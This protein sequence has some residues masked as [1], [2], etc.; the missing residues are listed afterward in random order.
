M[1]TNKRESRRAAA[2][3]PKKQTNQVLWMYGLAIVAALFVAFQIYGPALNG[4]F[5]FDDLYLPMN[6]PGWES[7]S[8]SSWMGRVRPLLMLSYWLNHRLSGSDTGSYHEWNVIFHCLNALL[9]YLIARKL[10]QWSGKPSNGLA[11]FAGALFLMHPVQTEAVSYIAGRSDDLSS[12]FFFGAYALF[13]YRRSTA[14]S[15][16]V[17]LGVLI[18]FGAAAGT[19]ENTVVLPAL[20]VLTDYFWNPGFSFEGIRR[21]WRLYAPLVVGGVLGAIKVAGV[22]GSAESAGFQMKDLTWYQYLFTQ[23]RVFF[24]YLRL[25]FLPA[26]QTVDYDFPISHSLLDQGSVWGLVGILALIG[27]AIHYRRRYPLACFGFFAFVI[28]LA[29]TSSIIPIRDPISERRLYLPMIGLLL[30]A[31]EALGR[32]RI[33][34]KALAVGLS[35]LLLIAAALTYRRNEVWS[36]AIPLWQDAVEK[37]PGKARAHFQLGFAYF[38]ANRCQDAE[39]QYQ[40][41]AKIEKPDARLLTDWALTDNCLNQ[42][43][44]AITKLEQAAALE[45]TAHVYTQLAMMYAKTNQTARALVAL[46]TAQTLDPNFGVTYVYRGQIFEGANDFGAAAQQFRRAL[47]INPSD[48]QALQ[49]M[50]RLRARPRQ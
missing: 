44:E 7:S 21:N 17:A 45:K 9:V 31:L 5:L 15:W 33:E 25:F 43:G 10:L 24:V 8:L 48:E 27:A 26:A 47:E 11:L 6:T 46:Q 49:G 39:T 42:S 18:L 20:L 2:A 14:T 29:P 12:L 40:A 22:L 1:K 16:P 35:A 36:G 19:K 34:R 23:F 32:L 28:L 30:V 13:L 41:V 50:E 4:P 37:S 3:E 38:T